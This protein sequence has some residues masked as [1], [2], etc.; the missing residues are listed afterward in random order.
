M[1]E[2]D[3]KRQM[4]ISSEIRNVINNNIRDHGWHACAVFPK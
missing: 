3:I 4:M 2:N 1:T